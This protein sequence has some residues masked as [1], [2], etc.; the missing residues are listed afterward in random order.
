[1]PLTDIDFLLDL[2][3]GKPIVPPIDSIVEYIENKRLM[4]P[5]SP[6]P[7]FYDSSY[8]P[9]WIE[10]MENMSPAS[11]IRHTS[12]M[13][14]VQTGATTGVLENPIAFYVG[15]Q[16]SDIQYISATKDN[17]KKWVIKKLDPLIDS[18]GLRFLIDKQT[19]NKKSRRTGDQMLLKEFLGGTLLM[20]S[21]QTP[22]DMRQD[23]VKI[24][25]RD[26][27]DG[28]PTLLTTGE[29]NWL[30]VSEGRT[31]AFG[32]RAKIID[33]ST[34]TEYD[35]SNIRRMYEAGDQRKFLVP[36]P[37]CG[38][39]QE[40]QWGDEDTKSG[41]KA[42]TKAGKVISVYYACQRCGEAI[43]NS[44]KTYML[45]KGR[46]APTAISDSEYRRSYH[47]STLYSPIGMVSWEQIYA[48]YIKAQKDPA[49]GMRSFTNL[50]LGLPYKEI[51]KRINPRD[52]SR[53][54]YAR[55]TV[56]EGVLFLT[57]SVDVQKGVKKDPKKPPRLEMEVCG[58]GLGYRTWSIDH[59]VIKGSVDDP[60]DGAWQE[61]RELFL[62][63]KMVFRRKD[64]IVIPLKIMLIDSQY[65][66][67]VVYQ[68]CEF[69]TANMFAIKGF[70]DFSIKKD[71]DTDEATSRDYNRFK[72]SKSGEHRFY[73]IATVFYKQMLFYN[74]RVQRQN[75]GPQKRGF[76][77]FPEDY[78]DEYFDQL[79]AEQMMEGGR[80]FKRI[81]VRP[82]EALDL[83]VYNLAASHIWL[84]DQVRA[85]R[86]RKKKLGFRP[87]QLESIDSLY[88]LNSLQAALDAEV[89]R[90]RSSQKG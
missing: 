36:C 75:P 70:K 28:A 43:R 44:H 7:G 1:M 82:N 37:F 12:I 88:I 56:P 2:N 3:D 8:T 59:K 32:N 10:P 40:L 51:G 25:L 39:Y 33:V 46:W 77:E 34:P 54:T 4:P 47:I 79:T 19:D 49:D 74:L 69:N 52:I 85:E 90:V 14:A 9:Y 64:G 26:E 72:L 21:A 71:K 78:P 16:P 24:L 57:A 81:G 42:D 86:N 83:R 65:L 80:T 61:L 62:K 17:L 31:F 22:T 60:F 53:G 29:G 55:G 76:C 23:S 89:K 6:C 27:I 68:F 20:G 66:P 84:D 18:C 67:N 58:H 30:D 35:I 48:K 63:E 41:L 5:N 13:K 87:E 73:N 45:S 50:I 11:P 15:A 38:E